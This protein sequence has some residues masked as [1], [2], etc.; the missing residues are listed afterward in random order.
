MASWKLLRAR[1]TSAEALLGRIVKYGR[2]ANNRPCDEAGFG[3]EETSKYW[4]GFCRARA[5]LT[6]PLPQEAPPTCKPWCAKE[7]DGSMIV[8]HGQLFTRGMKR[9]CSAECWNQDRQ[10]RPAVP[11]TP[12]APKL[13]RDHYIV[14]ALEEMADEERS[15]TP[16]TCPTCAHPPHP[17][18]CP[19][20]D[21]R[22]LCG[23]Q[24]SRGGTSHPGTG[25]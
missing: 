5:F 10:I 12:P 1:L 22:G 14:E 17:G 19:T 18:P 25:R 8:G 3:K 13:S 11:P 16:T 21:S 20:I 24:D 15:T 7:S 6:E 23:C 9:Y 2:C 4:C